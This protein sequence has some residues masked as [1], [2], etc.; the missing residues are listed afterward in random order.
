MARFRLG[1]FD[2]AERVPYAKIPI[3]ENDSSAHRQVAR[4]A[5]RAAIVLLKNEGAV[6]PLS[7]SVRKIAVVGPSADDPVALLGNYNGISSKQVT[8]LE[9]I[10]RQF[11]GAEV[12]YALGATYTAAALPRWFPRHS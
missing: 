10:E 12:R 4:D 7:R 1:M 9:G 5:E 6:L 3:S 8:P 2:P 11:P